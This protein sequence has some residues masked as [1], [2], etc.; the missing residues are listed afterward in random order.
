MLNSPSHDLLKDRLKAE[1]RE[2]S[3]SP[4]NKLA[5]IRTTEIISNYI[6]TLRESIDVEEETVET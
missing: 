1:I 5:L 2:V 6:T 4:I 3:A